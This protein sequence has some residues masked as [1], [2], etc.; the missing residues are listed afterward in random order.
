[1]LIDAFAADWMDV[2]G[3][4]M[5][6]LAP[7]NRL[8]LLLDGAFVPG[9]H[10][11][12]PSEQ[13]ALLFAALPGCSDQV[14]DASPFLTPYVPA[15][16]T[17]RP[18]LRR[19]DQWPMVSAIE[20]PESL[21]TLTARL[22]AWC[23]IEADGQRFNFRFPDTRRLPAIFN[24]L[25]PTQRAQIAGPAIRWSYVGR[26]GVWR[27]LCLVPSGEKAAADPVLDDEQFASLVGDSQA[28]ELLVLLR[29]RGH[30]VFRHPSKSHALLDCALR[31]ARRGR[32]ESGD[33][34]DWCDWYWL[35]A[36]LEDEPTAAATLQNWRN[37]HR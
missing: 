2:L 34:L 16:R 13:K 31:A 32:L 36:R 25:G 30:A 26:D 33:V 29:D 19:C 28:D 6:Q 10:K 7:S 37:S 12:L 24:V 20:T 8:F 17:M 11:M 9:L 3:A 22:S 1:M 21:D 23:V 14:K 15:E 4:R 35:R 18:L 27:E 5:E